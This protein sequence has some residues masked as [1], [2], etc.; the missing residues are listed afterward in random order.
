MT[1]P[2]CFS[3]LFY[4]FIRVT[5]FKKKRYLCLQAGTSGLEAECHRQS[6][7]VIKYLYCSGLFVGFGNNETFMDNTELQ[8]LSPT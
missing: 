4:L 6:R 7:E 5:V 1:E 2:S 8:Y 3:K